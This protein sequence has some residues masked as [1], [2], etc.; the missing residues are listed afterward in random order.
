[1]TFGNGIT[2][3]SIATGMALAIAVSLSAVAQ[4]GGPPPTLYTPEPDA[5]D[6]KS[7]LFNWPWHM[8][9]LR[10]IEEHELQVSLEYRAEGTIQ[11]NG[12]ACAIAPFKEAKR[13]AQRGP[14]VRP[15]DGGRRPISERR[16][17]GQPELSQRPLLLRAG[18]HHTGN[19]LSPVG[20]RKQRI[21]VRP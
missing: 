16:G 12:Q 9:M 10:G 7:V 11:V 14:F 5:K 1:M 8:G 13:E 3:K 18:R 20:S 2:R 15:P 4:F 19:S 6:L 21:A 17:R